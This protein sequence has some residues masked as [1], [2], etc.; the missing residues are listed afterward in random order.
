MLIKDLIKKYPSPYLLHKPKKPLFYLR[1][2]GVRALP[3]T[4]IIARSWAG[5]VC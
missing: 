4:T 2:I 1:E 5:V 3:S